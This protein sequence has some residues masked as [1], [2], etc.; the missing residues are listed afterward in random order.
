KPSAKVAEPAHNLFCFPAPLY[1]LFW[2]DAASISMDAASILERRTAVPRCA[3]FVLSEI[4]AAR[5][6]RRLFALPQHLPQSRHRA[7]EL[8]LAAGVSRHQP[9]KYSK[10]S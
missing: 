10:R 6:I 4:S 7:A 1:F 2:G 3:L 5:R 8:F 9:K